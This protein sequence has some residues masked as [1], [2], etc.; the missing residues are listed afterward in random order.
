MSLDVER[1]CP[2]IGQSVCKAAI[3][4]LLLVQSSNTRRGGALINTL[5]VLSVI[6]LDMQ[7]LSHKN[8]EEI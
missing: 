6:V 1:L 4:D 7:F 8:C 2:R 3:R 5:T